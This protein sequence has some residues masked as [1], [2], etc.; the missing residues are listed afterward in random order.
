MDYEITIMKREPNPKYEP[1]QDG[2]YPNVYEQA[3][4]LTTQVLSTVLTAEEFKKSAME[5]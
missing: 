1:K 2:R 3:E 5:S 4:Y